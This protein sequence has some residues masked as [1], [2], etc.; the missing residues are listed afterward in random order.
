MLYGSAPGTLGFSRVSRLSN[1]SRVRNVMADSV[2]GVAKFRLEHDSW[3]SECL[4]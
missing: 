4:P 3:I 1:D 2:K